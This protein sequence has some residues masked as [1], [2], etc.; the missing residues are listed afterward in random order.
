[1][2]ILNELVRDVRFFASPRYLPELEEERRPALEGSC[3]KKRERGG[4]PSERES[5]P[6]GKFGMRKGLHKR[7]DAPLNARNVTEY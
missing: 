4:V 2:L 6:K 3:N 5:L 7:R 1:M